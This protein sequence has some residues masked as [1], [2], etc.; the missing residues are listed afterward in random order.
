MLCSVW[1]ETDPTMEEWTPRSS[2]A[3]QCVWH[4]S[5]SPSQ[6]DQ[7]GNHTETTQEGVPSAPSVTSGF[8]DPSVA[9]SEA[10]GRDG[11]QHDGLRHAEQCT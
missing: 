2:D 8:L 10:G 5:A 7:D 6:Q 4:P 3:V 1:N 11:R 9:I